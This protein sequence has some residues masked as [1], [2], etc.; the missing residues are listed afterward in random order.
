MITTRV[1]APVFLTLLARE[2]TEQ[3]RILFLD[4]KNVLIALAVAVAAPAGR[5]TAPS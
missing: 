5:A 2:K 1:T 3:F 4:R